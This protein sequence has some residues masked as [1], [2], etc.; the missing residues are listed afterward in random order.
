MQGENQLRALQKSTSYFPLLHFEERVQDYLEQF[1]KLFY[2]TKW[3]V[4]KRLVILVEKGSHFTQR[5]MSMEFA[6]IADELFSRHYQDKKLQ[7]EKVENLILLPMIV[8][9]LIMVFY[10]LSPFLGELLGG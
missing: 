6:Q 8:D 3:L 9:L 5:D 7:A 2:Y 1:Q 4:I 10:L